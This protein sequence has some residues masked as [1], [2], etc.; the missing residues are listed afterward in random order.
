MLSSTNAHTSKRKLTKSPPRDVNNRLFKSE[1]RRDEA[2]SKLSEWMNVARELQDIVRQQQFQIMSHT[3]SRNGDRSHSNEHENT[4]HSPHIAQLQQLVRTVRAELNKTIDNEPPSN[5]TA[6]SAPRTHHPAAPSK[7]TTATTTASADIDAA[8]LQAEIQTL[9][10]KVL[11]L[12]QQQHCPSLSAFASS[13]EASRVQACTRNA[14]MDAEMDLQ[15]ATSEIAS[16]RQRMVEHEALHQAHAVEL[17]SSQKET[18]HAKER[19]EMAE[20]RVKAILQE[21]AEAAAKIEQLTAEIGSLQSMCTQKDARVEAALQSVQH[22]NNQLAEAQCK[23]T[24]AEAS[25]ALERSKRSAIESSMARLQS[26]VLSLESQLADVTRRSKSEAAAYAAQ[27][28]AFDEELA[29]CQQEARTARREADAAREDRATLQQAHATAVAQAKTVQERLMD[30]EAEREAAVRRAVH[31][32]KDAADAVATASQRGAALDAEKMLRH[33]TELRGMKEVLDRVAASAQAK[34]AALEHMKARFSEA[35]AAWEQKREQMAEQLDAYDHRVKMVQADAAEEVQLW[36]AELVKAKEMYE[37]RLASLMPVKLDIQVQDASSFMEET[38]KIEEQYKASLVASITEEQK[39]HAAALHALEEAHMAALQQA[40]EDARREALAEFAHAP[41]SPPWEGATAVRRKWE[42]AETEAASLREEVAV[43]KQSLADHRSRVRSSESELLSAQSKASQLNSAI[44]KLQNKCKKYKE[45]LSSTKEKLKRMEESNRALQNRVEVAE[46]KS[47][48]LR[49]E[50]SD[51]QDEVE[52]LLTA[53]LQALSRPSSEVDPTED[54]GDYAADDQDLEYEEGEEDGIE[55][56]I[57]TRHHH[58]DIDVQQHAAQEQQRSDSYHQQQ[59][60]QPYQPHDML[61][62]RDENTAVPQR[63]SHGH[64][65][66]LQ[67]NTPREGLVIEQPRRKPGRK[68]PLKKLAN[69]L[70]GRKAN[71]AADKPTNRGGRYSNA[72][73]VIFDDGDHAVD[74]APLSS[75]MMMLSRSSS[76]VASQ[77][78]RGPDGRIEWRPNA[79]AGEGTLMM[80]ELDN[81]GGWRGNELY[82]ASYDDDLEY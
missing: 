62:Y 74:H 80:Q 49:T 29:K 72:G 59:H 20:E 28:E 14:L 8:C 64:E 73:D 9:R 56:E 11:Y 23:A 39:E 75:S 51:A 48:A 36:Q 37:S 78:G 30:A 58:Q 31:A 65:H 52:A 70:R 69:L 13:E 67:P 42:E 17:A 46:E 24:A 43:L 55:E 21:K 71:A 6:T 47:S 77:L 26:E 66:Q 19:V 68:S 38:A 60:P 45:E 7:S 57:V 76:G 1:M 32:E 5:S 54:A 40:R 2:E 12:Q 35:Q 27:L 81:E 22:V 53:R 4:P 61:Y 10:H 50:L 34:D 15:K 82:R 25:E 3:T 41:P 44:Q 18:E 63:Y 79:V 16:L 33:E